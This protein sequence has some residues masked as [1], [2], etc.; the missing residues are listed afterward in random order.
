[1]SI[2]TF[3]IIGNGS[4]GHLWAAYLHKSGSAFRLYGRKRKTLQQYQLRAPDKNFRYETRIH[5]IDDWSSADIVMIC[6]KAHA[7]K[8]LVCT[9]AN[10]S[11]PPN[12]IILMM[13]GMG[14]VEIV[15]Q[16]LP[17][18][19]I[20]HAAISHG[21]LLKGSSLFHTGI[22]ET[23][24][25]LV[26][27]NT[28]MTYLSTEQRPIKSREPDRFIKTATS[29]LDLS[30][31][32]TRWQ[33]R[34]FEQ[35]WIKLLINSVIN[36]LTLFYDVKNGQIFR[37]PKIRKHCKQLITE[38]EPLLAK[39]L[40]NWNTHTLLDEIRNVANKTALNSSS[41]REDHLNGKPTEIKFITGY[42]LRI[43]KTHKIELPYHLKLFDQITKKNN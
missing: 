22:G 11:N 32:K 10:L 8:A 37:N 9:L 43:A 5:E 12:T 6:V 27:T 30:L 2:L 39:I 21:A 33:N 24:I 34:Q 14:L 35:L 40:P 19:K 28:G 26:D 41:M 4:I 25:G 16:Y 7:L 1:M 31:P 17:N 18:A 29:L 36:P 38:L 13:N 20:Y 3:N 23:Q 15:N 42:L